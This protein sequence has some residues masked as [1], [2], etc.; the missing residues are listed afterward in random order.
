MVDDAA[1]ASS[2]DE[3]NLDQ[4][5]AYTAAIG[6]ARHGRLRDGHLKNVR[7]SIEREGS[8]GYL[9]RLTQRRDECEGLGDAPDRDLYWLPDI[10]AESCS[11]DLQLE[12]ARERIRESDP[13]CGSIGPAS[14]LLV[15]GYP[16]HRS[17]ET[18]V[19]G[20]I[21]MDSL[22]QGRFVTDVSYGSRGGGARRG[23]LG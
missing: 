19:T 16:F 11:G 1:G 13:H 18:G 21:E 5:D 4:R 23:G 17:H 9:G 20:A 22:A 12:L 8:R 15:D 7:I 2:L 3:A 10:R 14:P 6:A